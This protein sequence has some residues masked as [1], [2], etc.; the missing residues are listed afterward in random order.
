MIKHIKV[1]GRETSQHPPFSTHRSKLIVIS[2]DAV[3]DIFYTFYYFELEFFVVIQE[4]G[5]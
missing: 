3:G 4:C 5:S 2:R 1:Y